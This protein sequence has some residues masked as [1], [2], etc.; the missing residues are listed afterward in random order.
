MICGL[1]VFIIFASMFKRALSLRLKEYVG[2]FPCVVVIGPRQ[3]GKTTLVK[4]YLLGQKKKNIYLDMELRTDFNKLLDP[5]TYLSRYE[6]L[7]VVIDE[8]QRNKSLFPVLRALIDRNRK[9]GRFILLGSAAP[10]LIRDSSESL[11]GRIGYIELFPLTVLEVEKKVSI[12]NLW[13]KGGFP[14]A[15]NGKIPTSVWMESFIRTYLEQD[16]P[17]LG[18]PADRHTANKL[19]SMLA[20]N[21]GGITNY[22]DLSKST[23]ISASTVKNYIRFLENAFLVR[24]LQPYFMNMKKRLVKAPKIYLRDSGILHHFLGIETADNL[25]GHI[26][27]GA[28]WEGFVIEQIAALMP[29][30][31]KLFFYRT[32]DGAELD[33]VIE[34]GGKPLAAIEIKYGSDVLA[35]KGN[36]VAAKTLKTKMNFIIT[37]DSDEYDTSSGFKVLGLKKFL[38]KHLPKF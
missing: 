6:N 23:E 9:N 18:F 36:I 5:E 15:L 14:D 3:V 8:V 29:P 13:L 34:K 20:H 10:D 33:L 19:W 11:A 35:S 38:T 22:T 7:T 31:L 37:K 1:L 32:H 16:L 24:Q 21:H 4:Q 12:E 30:N 17:Q 2:Y 26:K 25:H 28:S 27:M